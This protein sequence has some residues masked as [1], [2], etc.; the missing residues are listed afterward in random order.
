MHAYYVHLSMLLIVVLSVVVVVVV[1][2]KHVLVP[3]L[4]FGVDLMYCRIKILAL[5]FGRKPY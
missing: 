1:V 3:L 4:N 2:A 5:S